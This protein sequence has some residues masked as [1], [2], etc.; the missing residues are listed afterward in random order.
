MAIAE[1]LDHFVVPV[2]D[3]I[4][5]EEFYVGVFG[6]VITK[7][8]GLNTRQ[9]KRGA[10]P[11]TFIQIGGKRMGVY[12]QSEERPAPSRARGL[13]TYSFTTTAQG[14]QAVAAE[15]NESG[16][17]F[18]GPVKN[19]YPFAH[20]SLFMTDPAGNHYAIYTPSDST[21][22]SASSNGRMTGVG[23]IEL[24]A[25]NVNDSVDFYEKVLG[26]EVQNRT[27]DNGQATLRMASGQTLILTEAPFSPKG[28]VMSRKVPGPH[29]AF[30]IPA[31]K[32]SAAL[33]HL[34]ELKIANGDRGAAKERHD[35]QGGTYMDDPAGYVIQFITDGME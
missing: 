13:P 1:S 15:L 16:A 18:D 33:A 12:L 9:R 23:Y 7:R 22:N 14:L 10:V 6:G 11:H 3:I 25:P 28:L 5:A 24:E 32:W 30:Y 20:Q 17:R 2:D 21:K 27:E 4:V 26:F 19:A 34:D 31:A 35:G 8:N 29:I